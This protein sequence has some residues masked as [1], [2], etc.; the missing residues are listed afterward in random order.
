MDV[1]G[2]LSRDDVEA[3]LEREAIP[4][5]LSCHRPD[6][7]LWMLSL[8]FRY[9]EGTIQ[10]ATAASADVISFLEA[11]PAV[12]FEVST[13]EPPYRGVRGN[14][15]ATITPDPEK[16]VLRDL[17]ERYLETTD[18]QLAGRLLD[19]DREEVTIEIEPA[20]V[21]GWDFTDRMTDT[22]G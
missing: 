22:D 15:T 2:S 21:Y 6:G 14:G 18:G 3:F 7:T 9:R 10:C 20:T 13:N 1:R 12:A 5:R 19:A 16:T 17:L 8:W 11:D 4:L